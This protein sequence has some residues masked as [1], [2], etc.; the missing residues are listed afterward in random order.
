MCATTTIEI[1][2]NSDGR[3]TGRMLVSLRSFSL[4]GRHSPA[5][6]S[7]KMSGQSMQ[8]PLHRKIKLPG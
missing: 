2:G 4:Q 7:S 6:D 5:R 3:L 8:V 1:C